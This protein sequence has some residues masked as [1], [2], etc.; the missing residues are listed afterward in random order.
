[1]TKKAAHHLHNGASGAAITVHIDHSDTRTAI[2][3]VDEGI[4]HICL[5]G[6]HTNQD[7]LAFLA[8]VLQVPARQL[9]IVGGE[10]GDDKLITVLNLDSAAVEKRILAAMK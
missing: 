1:M 2:T 8:G 4:I 9:E 7:L 5:A 6:S 3:R 10:G